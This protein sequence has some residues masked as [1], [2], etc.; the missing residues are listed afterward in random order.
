MNFTLSCAFIAAG[1]TV[2]LGH[3]N[4][5][6]PQREEILAIKV[7]PEKHLF[8][9]PLSTDTVFTHQW[10]A[11]A[12]ATYISNMMLIKLSIGVFLLRL[13]TQRRYRWTIWGS[14][15]IIASMSTALF[16]WDIFQCNPVA[17]QWDYT[18]PNYTCA[19][20]SQV[21]TV[22]YILSVLNILSDW[23]YALLPIPML[24]KA[25]MTPQA[26]ITVSVVLGLGIL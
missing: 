5:V 12:T 8:T 24:W 21:V 10:Q 14:M 3:H 16:L 2:G 9:C 20:A 18:I 11:L 22:A 7:R 25:R 6:L 17:A 15:G 26:K 13:A 4:A 23:L 1:L 19:S